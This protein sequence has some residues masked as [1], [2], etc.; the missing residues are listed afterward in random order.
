[1]STVTNQS[2][3][4]KQWYTAPVTTPLQ[5]AFLI[6]GGCT[7]IALVSLTASLP[8]P[9]HP[10]GRFSS[11]GDDADNATLVV[12]DTA[13]ML[14][15]TILGILAAPLLAFIYGSLYGRTSSFSTLAITIVSGMIT[16]VW[17]LLSFSLIYAN[18]TEILG[19][20]KTYYMFNHVGD[21][22]N[23]AYAPTIPFNIFAIFELAFALL[24]AS[25]V[26]SSI[27]GKFLFLF[28]SSS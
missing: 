25:I 2:N 28:L 5:K 3:L 11:Q 21:Q 26:I 27:L 23:L 12:G 8:V 17:V 19:Y 16:V 1:M 10:T 6:L 22:P 13:W 24:S 18:G 15:A 20:P 7:L 14:V 4:E 9:L